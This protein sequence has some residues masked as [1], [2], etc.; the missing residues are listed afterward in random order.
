MV[1]SKVQG[2]GLILIPGEVRGT[3]TDEKGTRLL[4]LCGVTGLLQ[5]QDF[6]RGTVIVAGV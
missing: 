1:E 5:Y 6:V 2:S 4:V 3:H